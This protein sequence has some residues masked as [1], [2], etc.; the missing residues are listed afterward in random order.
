MTDQPRV[1]EWILNQALAA[2]LRLPE[3]EAERMRWFLDLDASTLTGK[4]KLTT[5]SGLF[6]SLEEVKWEADAPL[7]FDYMSPDASQLR[8]RETYGG[9]RPDFQFWGRGLRKQLLLECK[10]EA[11]QSKK[12]LFHVQRYV[13]YLADHGFTGAVIYIVPLELAEGWVRLAEGLQARSEVRYGVLPFDKSMVTG[14][15]FDLVAVLSELVEE[16]TKLL[17]QSLKQI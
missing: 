4:I 5:L 1:R 7:K 2:F 10:A 14:L 17:E 16:S 9:V 11:Y 15:R 13:N 12:H 3:G 6:P 8:F